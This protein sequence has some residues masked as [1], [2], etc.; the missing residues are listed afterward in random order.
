MVTAQRHLRES[1]EAASS[2]AAAAS[3]IIRHTSRDRGHAN[4][5]KSKGAERQAAG[6]APRATRRQAAARRQKP[7]AQSAH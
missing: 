2:F 5:E 6:E 4:E 3:V 1:R 7:Q